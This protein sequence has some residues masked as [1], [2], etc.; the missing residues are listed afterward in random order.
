MK[1]KTA[2]IAIIAIVIVVA[3]ALFAY[4]N[5]G[6]G[7][8]EIKVTDARPPEN[9]GEATQVYLKYSKVEIHRSQSDSE[10]GW[11]TVIDESAW[12]NLTRTLDVNQTIGAKNLQAGAYNLIRFRILEALVTIGHANRTAVV[13][14]GQ[15]TVSILPG[16]IHVNPGH[17]TELLIDISV[18]VEG[19]E[20]AKGFRVIPAAKAIPV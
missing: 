6:T 8:L 19:T 17:T 1:W 14:S 18:K 11:N 10:S 5:Y 13:P 2:S 16:G 20:S 9:W 3:A 15:L 7:I 4:F 12:I